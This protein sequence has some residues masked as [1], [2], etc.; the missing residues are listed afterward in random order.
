[1][2]LAEKGDLKEFITTQ[3]TLPYELAQFYTAEIVNALEYIH[4]KGVVHRDIKPENIILNDKYH[5]KIVDFGTSTYVG[6]IFDLKEK[7]FVEENPEE[8]KASLIGTAEYISPEMINEGKCSYPGDLWAL[9]CILYQFFHGVTPFYAS[10]Q[11][12]IVQNILNKKMGEISSSINEDAKDL[13]FRLLDYNPEK[14]LG[15]GA[16]NSDNDYKALKQHKFFAGIDFDHLHK[17]DP[18]FK[19]NFAQS[20]LVVRDMSPSRHGL[21]SC[22]STNE[23]KYKADNNDIPNFCLNMNYFGPEEEKLNNFKLEQSSPVMK[24]K[25]TDP[26]FISDFLK[27]SASTESKKEDIIYE[28]I[29]KKKSPWFHYNTRKLV[30]YPN[31]IE[32]HDPSKKC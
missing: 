11:H 1:L 5:T 15:A 31:K 30:L 3:H 19:T 14:R 7:R 4:S 9:G 18:P 23:Q 8:S 24:K 26:S 10:T 22:P 20:P 16:K 25:N 13:I 12:L 28:E 17:I 21:N 2:E 32:Y 29:V 6:K 27:Q